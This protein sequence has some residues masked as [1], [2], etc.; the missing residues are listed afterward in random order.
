MARKLLALLPLL[1]AAYARSIN[2][3]SKHWGVI[4]AGS[5]GWFNYRHQAD[6]CHAYQ[7]LRKNGIP[8]ER[9]ITMMYDDIA[10][11]RENPT[12]GKII[13]RP[14]GP[15]V[16][17]GV[18][19]DYREEEVNP[20]N[21][22]KVLKGDKEGMVGIGN[23]RVLESGPND[24]VFVN[25]VD[26]GAPGIIA[27]G[28]KFLHASD[29]HHTILKMNEEQRYGQMVIYVEAC[30]SGSMFDKNLLPKDINVFATTA[31]NAHESSYACYMDKERKTFLGDVYS[32]RWMEDSDKEDLSTETLTKQFEIV[33][34]ETNT[35][36]VMEFGNLTM[37]SIDVAEFQGKNT[38]MHIFDK[39][40]IP[41]PNLDAVPS[42]DVEMNILQ[43]KVQL[44]E[45]DWERELVSQKLEDLKITRRRTEETFKHI[46]ALSVNNNKDLVYDLMTERLPLLAHDCYK[47]VTE[48]L[49]TNCPGLNLVKNDYAPRHLYTFVNLCE[50]QTPQE[51]IMGAIDKTAEDT[52]LC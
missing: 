45:S 13:N 25:F 48:Y 2:E 1:V 28:S 19:I 6:A 5:N 24:H 46:M 36:H 37:G 43:L 39:Q 41:N 35:S 18:K 20:E 17:H 38:E 14:D 26:H 16:Y 4:V 52:D 29:L 21:F 47:P 15:D 7:I 34:R 11:N 22:L 31:A 23:G 27:F 32:V 12:P 49:R 50:H 44:A 9:I 10:N 51:A 3:E 33:R 40:P 8:E 42:E 30:E